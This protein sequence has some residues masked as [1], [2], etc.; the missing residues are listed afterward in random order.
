MRKEQLIKEALKK[1]IEWFKKSGIMIPAD[2]LWGVA[3]RIAVTSGNSSIEKIYASF[4][5]WTDCGDYSVIEQRRPDCNFETALMF[6]M[7]DEIFPNNGYAELAENILDFL[8]FRSGML[9]RFNESSPIGVWNWSHIKWSSDIWFD[10]NGWNC[11]I[12]FLIAE[13][14]PG[15]AAKYDMSG[16]GMKCAE[17]LLAGFDTTFTD[18]NGDELKELRDPKGVWLG[19]LML[20]HWG[21]LVAMALA[22]AKRKAEKKNSR[23]PPGAISKKSGACEKNSS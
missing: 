1:N 5:A 23:S 8:Y 13:R 2:G 6:L 12:Q 4:S 18:Y 11:I 3:E 14:Y 15:L 17:S 7:A 21:A 9:N 10:D 16:W 19:N 22:I 20:P